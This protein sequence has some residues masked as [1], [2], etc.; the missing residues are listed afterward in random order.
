[1]NGRWTSIFITVLLISGIPWAF[2]GGYLLYQKKAQGNPNAY[3]RALVA[4]P[5]GGMELPHDLLAELLDLS[6]DH[7]SHLYRIQ[8]KSLE[9]KLLSAFVFE[10]AHITKIHPSLLR[11][12]YKL[13]KPLFRIL[14]Q[15]NTLMDEHGVLFPQFPFYTPKRVIELLLPDTA[16][17]A[18][19]TQIKSS[20]LTL[21][22]EIAEAVKNLGPLRR[23]DLSKMNHPSLGKRE[24][25]LQIGS[26]YYR[27]HTTNWS[28]RLADAQKIIDIPANIIDFRIDQIAL[29]S[30]QTAN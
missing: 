18:W 12:E 30:S 17:Q 5:K 29:I 9:K 4:V 25:V 6:S 10:E 24:I 27:F 20:E 19:G 1:M 23:I 26:T 2:Y 28:S 16:P 21:L 8:T 13:R 11:V 3:I 15:E 14:S 22:L 7:P